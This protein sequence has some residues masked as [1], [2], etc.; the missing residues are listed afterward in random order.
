MSLLTNMKTRTKLLTSFIFMATLVA[1]VGI[2][3]VNGIKSMSEKV[4]TM[5]DNRLVPSNMMGKIF[6]SVADIRIGALNIMIEPDAGKRQA[7][8]DNAAKEEKEVN[9]YIEKYGTFPL[10]GEEKKVFEELKPAWMEYNESRLT[11]YNLALQGKPDEARQ[12]ALTKAGPKFKV[13]NEKVNRLIDMQD[14]LGKELDLESKNKYASLRNL[15]I[16]AV[17]FAMI[18]AIGMGLI[19]SNIIANPLLHG[20]ELAE[21]IADGDLTQK[22]NESTL[23][24]NDEIGQLMKSLD[25]M[26]LNL[27]N[28]LRSVNTSSSKLASASEE[29]SATAEQMSKGMQMQTSQTSQI[30]SAME[31]MSATVL[32]VAKNSQVVA[33]S[34]KE[35]TITADQGGEVVAK[36]VEGMERIAA[37]VQESAR[38]IGELGKSSDQIGEI[39][40]VIDDI[41]DQTNLL[42]LNAAIEAARAGEQGRGFAVVADEVRKLAERTTKATKEIA[43]MIK[44]IQR[45]TSNAV[46]AMESGT[47]EVSEG[48]SLANQAGDSLRT[49][50]D[51]IQKV[52]DMIVQIATAAEEQSSAAEEISSSIESI[53]A[54]TKETS[55]GSQQSSAASQD[56]SKMATELQRMVEQFKV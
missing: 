35:A 20:A 25:K 21:A 42:A 10:T 23:A 41:A 16:A 49:I 32:E 51:S 3:S 37:T 45:E 4:S 56:L 2:V 40:A 9:E 34:A 12:N 55:A 33:S 6:S 54:V 13:L 43:V 28:F 22:I 14:A 36:T 15:A 1:I 52:N 50:V 24:R 38:T 11:T 47:K 18:A 46:A 48:V 27:S 39:V 30:A 7:I 19:L 53:A 26:R 29:L 5:Y 44:N 8:F 31:E 17:I